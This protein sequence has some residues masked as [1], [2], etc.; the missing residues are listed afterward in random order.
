MAD[1]DVA[2]AAASGAA[3]GGALGSVAGPVGIGIGAAAGAIAQGIGAWIGSSKAE[4]AS[5]QEIAALQ[6]IQNKVQ[7]EWQN[8]QFDSTPLTPQEMT[9]LQKY[10]PQTAQYIQEKA[11]TMMT[12]IGQQQSIG[13]QKEAL[14]AL[15][16]LSQ[17]GFDPA[18]RAAMEQASFQADQGAKAQRQQVLNQLAARGVTGQEVLS[19]MGGQQSIDA[20]ARQAYLQSVQDAQQRRMQAIQQYAGLATNMRGAA[21]QQEQYNTGTQNAFNQRAAMSLREWQQNN[22]NAQNAAQQYN[23]N[24]AQNIAN[25]NVATSNQF[26]QY[27]QEQKNRLAQLAAQSGN[28]KLQTIAG[29]MS[30]QGQVRAGETAA[31]G[32]ALGAGIGALGQVASSV[33]VMASQAQQAQSVTDYNNAKANAL[34]TQ[35]NGT[36]VASNNPYDTSEEEEQ[37]A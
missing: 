15:Q 13:A 7:N 29:L 22:V 14:G 26:A 36:K 31:Q 33:P 30:Q 11:P 27:N 16:Q 24:S 19:T 23:I 21:A 3:T 32:Q 35:T 1:S 20:Q 12:G 8:P 5:K 9:L 37:Y 25:Q 10:V 34:N 4:A 17:T 2:S 28:Q 18:S 6:N